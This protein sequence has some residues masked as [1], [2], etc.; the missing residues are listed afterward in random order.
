MPYFRK[1]LVTLDGISIPVSPLLMCEGEE[2]F[3]T[4]RTV[5]DTEEF[6]AA[7][8]EA[9]NQAMKDKLWYPM[10]AKSLNRATGSEKFSPESLE[11]EFDGKFLEL[12]KAAICEESG[13]RLGVPAGETTAP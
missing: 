4:Q 9:R 10:I 11:K 2:F 5:R 3:S 8:F 13:I 7:T 1:H 12:L 6:K